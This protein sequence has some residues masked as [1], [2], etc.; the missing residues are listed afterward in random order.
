MDSKEKAKAGL[1]MIEEAILDLLATQ[2]EGLCNAEI[3]DALDLRS[4]YKG[5]NKDYLTWSILGRL[6]NANKVT[7]KG[8]KYLLPQ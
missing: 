3:A 6:L 5:G 2:P 8:R 4:D 1:Q 7:R